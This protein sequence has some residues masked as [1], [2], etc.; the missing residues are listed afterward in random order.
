MSHRVSTY[1]QRFFRDAERIEG[2]VSY[3]FSERGS[4]LSKETTQKIADGILEG[5]SDK[6]IYDGVGI[7]LNTFHKYISPSYRERVRKDNAEYKQQKRREDPS[8]K[9]KAKEYQRI[10]QA[11]HLRAFFWRAGK[12]DN[13]ITNSAS[14]TGFYMDKS[15][16]D[17]ISEGIL[18]GKHY[19]EICRD[20]EIGPVMFYKYIRLGYRSDTAPRTKTGQKKP[21]LLQKNA[22]KEFFREFGE[23]EDNL[24]SE[25]S[26]IGSKK[27][28]HRESDNIC[29]K[30]SRVGIRRFFKNA[31]QIEDMI[32]YVNSENGSRLDKD[33]SQ[34]IAG[35]ILDGK[36]TRQMCEVLGV[37]RSKVRNYLNPRL[38]E[39]R[40][41]YQKEYRQRPDVR[42][43]RNEYGRSYH[44]KSDVKEKRNEYQKEY[45]QRPGI[46]ERLAGCPIADLWKEDE[47]YDDSP[48]SDFLSKEELLARKKALGLAGS[49]NRTLV[50]WE[51]M[52]II[53]SVEE[54][55]IRRYAIDFSSPFF[56]QLDEQ[57]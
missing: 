8:F 53:K 12:I 33:L 26:D 47:V 35:I 28:G 32:S 45:R 4:R 3:V 38:W 34:N 11:V 36:N 39:K 18:N 16:V 21:E 14:E 37:D 6:E 1:L 15:C 13:L 5:K 42:E 17:G 50:N 48:L 31:D 24:Y 46:T 22:Q 44:Q 9:S 7:S 49:L 40:K 57:E 43:R 29:R 23:Q 19:S 25:T 10:K 52:G 56:E 27:P 2:M 20:L 51:Y 55:G 41:K 54:N 30:E